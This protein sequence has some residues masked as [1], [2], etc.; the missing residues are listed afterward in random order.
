VMASISTSMHSPLISDSGSKW[1]VE[2]GR[3]L[4]GKWWQS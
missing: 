2:D 3:C 4:S 1:F